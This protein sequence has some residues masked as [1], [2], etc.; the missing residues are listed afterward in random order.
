MAHRRRGETMVVP[1]V[2]TDPRFTSAERAAW[3]AGGVRAAVT[4][5]LVKAGR[6]VG[7]FGVQSAAPR[8]WTDDEVALVEAT[9]DRTWAAVERARAEEAVRTS[10][11]RQADLL[12]LSDALR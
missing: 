1:D 7:D 8:E 5:A 4:V 2:M 9:A 3:A 6:F 10:E 11:E 12:K